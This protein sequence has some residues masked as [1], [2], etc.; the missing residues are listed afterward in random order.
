[1][2][3]NGQIKAPI[4]L[5]DDV[6]T[7]LGIS[8]SGAYYDL[9]EA[10]G[11]TSINKWSKHKPYITT[12][13][14]YEPIPYEETY[15]FASAGKVN[16]TEDGFGVGYV[17]IDGVEKAVLTDENNYAIKVTKD[18]SRESGA[19][20][21]WGLQI[22][23]PSQSGKNLRD[24]MLSMS[25]SALTSWYY[26]QPNASDINWKR[27]TD[28]E[29]YNHS[30]QP[31]LIVTPYVSKSGN[32]LSPTQ[33][34]NLFPNGGVNTNIIID[35]ASSNANNGFNS[36]LEFFQKRPDLRFTVEMWPQSSVNNT[37][38]S[39]IT[40]EGWANLDI[41]D[42]EMLG[43]L[44]FPKLTFDPAPK[45]IMNV[46]A[47]LSSLFGQDS[48]W[49]MGG[50]KNT[51]FEGAFK[52]YYVFAFQETNDH[53]TTNPNIYPDKMYLYCPGNKDATISSGMNSEI[54]KLDEDPS[55]A[56]SAVLIPKY[57][58]PTGIIS[59]Q[60]RYWPI[61]F[62]CWMDRKLTNVKWGFLYG[63]DVAGKNYAWYSN[64]AGPST[65]TG[66]VNSDLFVEFEIETTDEAFTLESSTLRY[67]GNSVK[68]GAL[69][70]GTY[71]GNGFPIIGDIIANPAFDSDGEWMVDSATSATDSLIVQTS[72]GETSGKQKIYLRFKNFWQNTY[73]KGYGCKFR[74]MVSMAD[75]PN[76]LEDGTADYLR[77]WIDVSS[78]SGV[79]MADG[80]NITDG[81]I[82]TNVYY[83]S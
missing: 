37:S 49:H 16:T 5:K 51:T 78:S 72:G 70:V 1:M 4:S 7:V 20:T 47:N 71:N 9:A 50:G 75:D 34:I 66:I 21:Y 15:L 53:P 12:D 31:P 19:A 58:M 2:N 18:P 59:T 61:A 10:C 62:G 55:L 17:T 29:Y 42:D 43:K 45:L 44:F 76:T 26:D 46:N 81:I 11:S 69:E 64:E 41:N 35:V 57:N 40:V 52:I 36:S 38:G 60:L 27:L 79:I 39:N 56:G 65:L 33:I 54:V 22:T 32:T 48:F 24:W 8:P 28:F 80:T 73:E 6:Y 14:S 74:F 82:N 63:S 13:N 68:F 23:A 83:K 77:R 67:N 3:S 30:A 25:P